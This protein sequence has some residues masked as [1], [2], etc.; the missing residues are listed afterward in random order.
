MKYHALFLIFEE[1][2]NFEIV[3]TDRNITERDDFNVRYVNFSPC[4]VSERPLVA[5][6]GQT[7]ILVEIK[8]CVI[9]YVVKDMKTLC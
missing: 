4:K 7:I 1:A 6:G 9:K 2:A 3:V 5:R 8:V